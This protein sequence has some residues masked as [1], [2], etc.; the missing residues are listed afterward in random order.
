MNMRRAACRTA[1][2]AAVLYVQVSFILVVA[3]GIPAYAQVPNG[4]SNTIHLA[5]IAAFVTLVTPL[6][7]V[8]VTTYT[9][10][11]DRAED[12]KD[13][14][15]VAAQVVR[16]AE[17]AED[18]ATLLVESN[19]N[20][21]AV[22]AQADERTNGQL[23]QIHTL[24]N[25]EKTAGYVRELALGREMLIMMRRVENPS[26][27]EQ[28][29]IATREARVQELEGIIAERTSAAEMAAKEQAANPVEQR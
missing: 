25:S 13:R 19:A 3:Y 15:E 24:V 27:D 4:S 9:R 20:I 18:A 17:K 26:T 22:A 16:A 2:A 7:T 1:M 29:V 5:L 28:V 14:A 11:S 21:A 10:R 8:L 6:L 12:R 23:K